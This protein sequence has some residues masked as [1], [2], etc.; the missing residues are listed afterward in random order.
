MEL[1]PG[2]AGNFVAIGN[3]LSAMENLEEAREAYRQS[4]EL[5]P[6]LVEPTY[7]FGVISAMLEQNDEAIRAFERVIVLQP[8]F[9]EGHFGLGEV[10]SAAGRPA[11]AVAAYETAL[12]LK[13]DFADAAESLAAAQRQLRQMPTS[14]PEM[15]L[16]TSPR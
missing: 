11:E 10:L 1:A 16:G 5:D 8:D 3:I 7:N 14:V 12:S 13:P 6:D 4:I 2:D 9:A 15:P